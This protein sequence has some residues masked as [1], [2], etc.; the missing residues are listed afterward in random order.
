MVFE[1]LS[2]MIVLMEGLPLQQRARCI[3]HDAGP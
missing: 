1:R 2:K 3:G